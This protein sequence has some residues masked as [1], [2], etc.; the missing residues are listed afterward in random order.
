MEEF[1][2]KLPQDIEGEPQSD[3]QDLTNDL[4]IESSLEDFPIAGFWRRIAA[5][6]IDLIVM[7]IPLLIFGFIFR[8]FAYSLGPWGR[9]IGYS[10][11]LA[12]WS[13]YNSE[14]RG[15]QT[16]GKRVS[17]IAVVNADGKF[18]SIQNSFK[19]ASILTLIGLLNGWSI[20]IFANP[21]LLALQT[22][23]VFG[24]LITI[25]YGIVFNRTTRQGV[26]DLLAGSYVIKIPINETKPPQQLPKIHKNIIYSIIGLGV[27]L[28]MFGMSFYTFN[29]VDRKPFSGL[30]GEEGNLQEL[31]DKIA[32]QG[33][34]IT[35]GIQRISRRSFSSAETLED[36][37]ID[38]WAKESCS[39][40]I[41]NC[42]ELINQV[43]KIVLNDYSEIEEL[44]GMQI[45]IVNRFDFG[46]AT[47]NSTVGAQL[48]IE[49]WHNRLEESEE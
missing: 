34:F 39:H 8:G 35:V 18:L 20:S 4:L 19:R 28:G 48:R 16:I 6:A 24:G 26:H 23:V 43:A 47:S 30:S 17:K 42:D 31:H 29:A 3:A 41:D 45:A 49:D 1:Q 46:L 37:N 21:I 32:R 7:A 25:F 2:Q 15:G 22:I 33:D 27:I 44:T 5:I 36:I 14:R 11:A 40:T 10:F 13:F 38:I 9:L 12:Y